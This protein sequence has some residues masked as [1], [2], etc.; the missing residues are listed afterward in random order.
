MTRK[1]RLKDVS[2]PSKNN[3]VDSS[4]NNTDNLKNLVTQEDLEKLKQNLVD[5]FD[6][7]Q[8]AV[9]KLQG[10]VSK[11]LEYKENER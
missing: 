5:R 10:S 7:T 9:A 3:D 8:K 4:S 6:C 2:D 1:K 11:L